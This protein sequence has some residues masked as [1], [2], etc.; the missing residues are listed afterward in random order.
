MFKFFHLFTLLFA[1]ASAGGGYQNNG[2]KDIKDLNSKN[3]CETPEQASDQGTREIQK[4]I[5][6]AGIE[7]INYY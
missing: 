7:W 5:D 1:L 2:C 3:S 4:D 6:S